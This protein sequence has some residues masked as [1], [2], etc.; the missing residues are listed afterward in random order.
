MAKRDEYLS[1]IRRMLGG[2]LV[3]ITL[4]NG[5]N[6][7]N[8]NISAEDIFGGL[9]NILYDYQL[10]NANRGQQNQMGVDL[11]DVENGIAVQ[12]TSTN[13]RQKVLH[14]LEK[15]HQG[16]EPERLCDRF[17]RLIVLILTE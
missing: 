16:A 7:Q 11:I 5:V 17:G 1:N 2:F 6:R 13:T 10:E 4:E 12:V 3:E 9:L 15:F 8:Q 14:T